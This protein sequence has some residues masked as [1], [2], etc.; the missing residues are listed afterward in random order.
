MAIELKRLIPPAIYVLILML[1]TGC[2]SDVFVERLDAN[3]SG[4]TLDGNGDKAIVSFSTSYIDYVSIYSYSD[5]S[6]SQ[7]ILD[8]EGNVVHDGIPS[9]PDVGYKGIWYDEF[10]SFSIERISETECIVAVEENAYP[11]P[12]E[13]TLSVSNDYTS[14][15][16]P[17]TLMPSDRYVVESIEYPGTSRRVYNEYDE[18]LHEWR[19]E[20]N[21]DSPMTFALNLDDMEFVGDYMFEEEGFDL[22][23]LIADRCIDVNVLSFDDW[24]MGDYGV[25]APFSRE[26]S[27]VRL[28]GPPTRPVDPV[29]A[30]NTVEIIRLY[31]RME[32]IG[33]WAV[34][35]CKNAKNGKAKVRQGLMRAVLP[36][37]LIVRR[38]VV[39]E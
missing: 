34:I 33:V 19:V 3:V 24:M 27:S 8:S 6:L 29:I 14:V 10:L 31:G 28:Q 12:Y 23:S 32:D 36:T 5:I 39:N 20:N 22:F 18:L 38:E 1:A 25:K 21:T 11:T 16:V 2:N 9:S 26:Y 17:V 37:F 35:N 30:P 7:K 13:F 4:L 15:E